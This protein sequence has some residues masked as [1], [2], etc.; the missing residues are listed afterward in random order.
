M[1]IVYFILGYIVF[2]I[3]ICLFLKGVRNGKT[4]KR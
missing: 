4:Y 1:T 3:I 2:V